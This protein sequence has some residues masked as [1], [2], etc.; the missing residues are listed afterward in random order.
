MGNITLGEVWVWIAGLLAAIILIGNA[1]DKIG[2]VIKALKAPNDDLK[3]DVD[4]LK[5]W[6]REVDRKL[7]NDHT[8]L[9]DIR[10]GN[11]A[12][13]QALLALLDHGIDGNN[14]SQMETAKEAVRNHL[15]K[16]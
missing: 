5:E 1:A 13:F 16:H 14:I 7:T 15:I 9:K 8:E 4:D 6:R 10:E 11:Q 2:S 3:A 12:I